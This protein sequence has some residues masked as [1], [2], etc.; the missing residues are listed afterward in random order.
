MREKAGDGNWMEMMAAIC[1]FILCLSQCV[2]VFG[3]SD[4][5]S[6]RSRELNQA[7][8]LAESVA[9]VWKIRGNRGLVEHLGFEEAERRE[10][11]RV[12]YKGTVGEEWQA[13]VDISKDEQGMM[14]GVVTIKKGQ[15]LF[16]LQV[17]KYLYKRDQSLKKGK[18]KDEKKVKCGKRMSAVDFCCNDY[19]DIWNAGL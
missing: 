9:E 2:L 13:A 19:G 10:K 4:Q 17:K 7:V 5:I 1:F 11:E 8:I 14:T 12:V 18:L 15:I 16:E 6:R 3:I